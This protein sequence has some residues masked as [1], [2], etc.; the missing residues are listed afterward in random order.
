MLL[1][2]AGTGVFLLKERAKLQR[3]PQERKTFKIAK[4][5][6]KEVGFQEEEKMDEGNNLKRKNLGGGVAA[7]VDSKSSNALAQ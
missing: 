4:R 3:Q 1:G 6:F 2:K 5:L 7:K